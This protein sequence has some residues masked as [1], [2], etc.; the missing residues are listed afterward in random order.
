MP[1]LFAKISISKK[2]IVAFL[3]VGIVP[4]TILGLT[5]LDSASKALEKQS[6]PIGAETKYNP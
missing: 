4:L 6:S 1:S 2:L 3:L 5:T